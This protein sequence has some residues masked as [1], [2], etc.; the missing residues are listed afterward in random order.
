M[1]TVS[2][3]ALLSQ[4]KLTCE[5]MIPYISIFS[6]FPGSVMTGSRTITQLYLE[7]PP[8]KH[9]WVCHCGKTVLAILVA[10]VIWRQADNSQFC[11][12]LSQ[13]LQKIGINIKPL[14][15]CDLNAKKNI[16]HSL[17]L[18]RL[19]ILKNGRAL[20]FLP[21]FLHLYTYS[22]THKHRGSHHHTMAEW[23]KVKYHCY[24]FFCMLIFLKQK[25]I[26][27]MRHL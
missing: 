7:H 4:V 23:Q 8:G 26:Q 19:F 21:T 10:T 27:F 15:R 13:C 6:P 5:N 14:E 9:Y 25:S 16:L 1:H 12:L 22:L 17:L 11:L 3:T 24:L 2:L 18:T 20:S